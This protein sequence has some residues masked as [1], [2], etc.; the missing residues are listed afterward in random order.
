MNP[1]RRI[2][3]VAGTFFIVAAVAAIVAL[4]L[5]GPLLSDS[6]YVVTASG[7]DTR[8]FLGAFFEVIVAIA[9]IG[10]AVTLVSNRQAAE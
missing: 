4:G 5:Y 7:D 2:A 8:I 10:T 9:V 1:T 6:R 3:V